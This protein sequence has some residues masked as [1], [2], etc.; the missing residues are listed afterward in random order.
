MRSERSEVRSQKCSGKK[1]IIPLFCLLLFANIALANQENLI[2]NIKQIIL[3]ELKKSVSEDVEIVGLRINGIDTLSEDYKISTVIMNGYIGRNNVNFIVS[4]VNNKMEKKNVAVDVSYDVLKDVF[5]AFRSLSKGT[6]LGA[7]DFYVIKQRVSKIPANAVLNR[8]D[9]EGK[10]LKNN[11]GQGVIIRGDHLT[12]QVGIKKGQKVEVVV[13][14]NNIIISTRGILRS[15]AMIGGVARVLC[16]VSKKEV[17]GILI[18][19][20]TVRLRI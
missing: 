20:N 7:D 5:V 15:D 16:E 3:K 18:S 17:S 9:V 1:I 14:G 8:N 19:P 2:G 6:V 13:E 11:I 12:D 10:V 4:L